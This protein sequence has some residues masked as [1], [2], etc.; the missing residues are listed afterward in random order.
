MILR[1]TA[2]WIGRIVELYGMPPGSGLRSKDIICENNEIE[3]SGSYDGISTRGIGK[4]DHP[5][6]REMVFG[7]SVPFSHGVRVLGRISGLRKMIGDDG[8]VRAFVVLECLAMY[9]GH[10]LPNQ[11]PVWVTEQFRELP[12]GTVTTDSLIYEFDKPK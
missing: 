7:K 3:L 9:G 4:L 6:P 12:E 2:A 10:D 11:K 1:D 5:W 8:I